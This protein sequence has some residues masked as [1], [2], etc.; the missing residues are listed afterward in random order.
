[1]I[2]KEFDELLE[3]GDKQLEE[4]KRSTF[5]QI[6]EFVEKDVLDYIFKSENPLLRLSMVYEMYVFYTLQEE[7]ER[8]RIL[9]KYLFEVGK[10]LG[11]KPQIR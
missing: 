2:G 9:R 1:M 7:Y 3:E 6:F 11:G 8:C 5:E 4:S 10:I